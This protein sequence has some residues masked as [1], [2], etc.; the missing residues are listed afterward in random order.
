MSLQ[1]WD[2]KNS[3]NMLNLIIVRMDQFPFML[4]IQTNEKI[5]GYATTKF[6]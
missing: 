5:L 2:E 6:A 1:D 4:Y 3:T